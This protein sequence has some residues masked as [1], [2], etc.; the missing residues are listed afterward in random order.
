MKIVVTEYTRRF[1]VGCATALALAAALDLIASAQATSAQY[2]GC[3]RSGTLMFVAIGTAPLNP[4]PRGSIQVSWR[5]AGIPGPQGPAGL[6]GIPG[7]AGP[8]GPEGPQG[9]VGSQGIQGPQGPQGP[10]G[11]SGSLT[12]LELHTTSGQTPSHTEFGCVV[13]G[14]GGGCLVFGQIR[15]ID[16]PMNVSAQCA[17]GKR[18][19]SLQTTVDNAYAFGEF[20]LLDGTATTDL[21]QATGGRAQDPGGTQLHSASLQ[22]VCADAM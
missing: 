5:E 6:Q 11:P 17:A 10:V 22:L 1:F 15:I 19:V 12:G 4:C 18:P 14:I 21:S 20:I 3:L 7:P 13:P 16:G 8:Q 9:P 2:T